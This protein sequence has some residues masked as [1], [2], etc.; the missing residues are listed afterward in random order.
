MSVWQ[1]NKLLRDWTRD[2]ENY[3]AC[4]CAYIWCIDGVNGCVCNLYSVQAISF[5]FRVTTK[6]LQVSFPIYINQ[7]FIVSFFIPHA[8]FFHICL[9]VLAPVWLLCHFYMK[10]WN[11]VEKTHNTNSSAASINSFGVVER[12]KW[13]AFE[14]RNVPT[15]AQPYNN[16]KIHFICVLYYNSIAYYYVYM[17]LC[18]LCSVDLN[19][20]IADFNEL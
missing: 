19:F 11:K 6:M 12:I 7:L 17:F 9:F 18:N 2:H 16:H 14:C 3:P 4:V 8:I 13:M 10:Q 1:L 15:N 5:S 20:C